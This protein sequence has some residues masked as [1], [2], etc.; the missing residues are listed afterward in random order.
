[1]LPRALSEELCSLKPKVPRLSMAAS[2][3]YSKDGEK[4]EIKLYNG[5]IESRRRATYTEIEAEKKDPKHKDLFALYHILKKKRFD[6]RH[7]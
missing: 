1:M 7:F 5:I 4:C 2:I 6:P 3:D